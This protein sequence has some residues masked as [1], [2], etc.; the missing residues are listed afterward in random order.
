MDRMA[1]A[2]AV[3][4]IASTTAGGCTSDEPEDD[5]THETAR[6]A[7]EDVTSTAPQ[8]HAAPTAAPTTTATETY[9]PEWFACSADSDCVVVQARACCACAVISTNAANEEDV[10][11]VTE[12]V[13]NCPPCSSAPCPPTPEAI[14]VAGKCDLRVD[15]AAMERAALCGELG[16]C[17]V[18]SGTP[19]S[20]E[21]AAPVRVGCF[22]RPMEPVQRTPTCGEDP[23]SHMRLRFPT[24][25]IPDGWLE[26]DAEQCSP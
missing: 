25:Q 4:A 11:R 24:S 19:C 17:L 16:K 20:R 7:A 15:C 21:A 13:P 8:P 3:S 9:A 6:D 18:L 2:L 22:L 12:D 23:E 1:F 26:C 14:C 5:G 10:R